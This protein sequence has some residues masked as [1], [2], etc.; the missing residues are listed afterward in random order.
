MDTHRVCYIKGDVI[1]ALGPRAKH[2]IMRG[3]WGRELKDVN[4]PDLLTVFKKTFLPARNV[5]PSMAQISNTK[6]ATTKH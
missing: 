4:L 3:Q 6:K 2:D 1:W 5:F